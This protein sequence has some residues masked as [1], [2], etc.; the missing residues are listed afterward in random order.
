MLFV[1]AVRGHARARTTSPV[2][3]EPPGP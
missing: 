2:A 3:G 1:R